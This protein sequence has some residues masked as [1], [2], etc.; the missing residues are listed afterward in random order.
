MQFELTDEVVNQ[1]IFSMED[2]S[3]KNA[4]D[5]VQQILIETRDGTEIDSDRYYSL[6]VWD[7]I[8]GFKVMEQFVSVLRS[9]L[10][11]EK[12]RSVLFIGKGVFRNFKNVLKEYPE[13]EHLWFVFKQK[14]MK[15]EI[16]GWYNVLRDSWGLERIEGEPEETGELIQGDFIFREHNEDSDVAHILVAEQDAAQ[17]LED[18]YSGELGFAAI[19]LWQLQKKAIVK[20][21]EFTLVAE[22][23]E[24]EFSGFISAAPFP[25]TAKKT[26]VFTAFFILPAWRGLG[27]GKELFFIFLQ[28]LQKR[29]IRWILILDMFIPET[30]TKVLLRSGFK[31]TDIGFTADLLE[32]QYGKN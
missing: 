5:S 28:K 17:I 4:F 11:K 31:K 13:V 10:A 30:F 14:E 1:L 3:E 27:I 7:S 15:K 9:P 32:T 19:S 24:G 25:T 22:T 21:S 29:G 16:I 18:A 2:Q 12:L 20:E 26:V 6:P 23:A 8:S